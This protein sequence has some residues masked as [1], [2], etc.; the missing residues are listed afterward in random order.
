MT[1]PGEIAHPAI[2]ERLTLNSPLAGQSLDTRKYPFL[3][4]RINRDETPDLFDNDIQAGIKDFWTRFQ[5]PRAQ[6]AETFHLDEEVVRGAV[7]ELLGFNGWAAAACS[8]LTRPFGAQKKDDDWSDL[9]RPG[10][11]Y[12]F[13]LVVH[14]ADHFLIDQLAVIVQLSK[15]LGPNSVFVSLVDYA[16]NDSTPF[17]C[18][19]AEAVMILLGI[20]FRIRQIPPMTSDPTASYYP[21]EEAYTR[22]LA[23]EPLFELDKRRNLRFSRVIWL[24][25][26]TCPND[27]LETIRVSIKN[28]ASMVCSM[29]WKEH[30]GFF[31]YNDRWRTR[32]MDGNLFR[33][34]KSTSPI[35]EA[36]PRD[37]YGGARY[38]LHLPFQVFCCE[39]GA[40]IVDPHK[41][42]YEGI[43]YQSSVA[44]VFNTSAAADGKT[45]KWSE[46]PCMD[47]SQLHFCRDMWMVAF[48][49]GIK[50][51]AH[52]LMVEERAG[53]GRKVHPFMEELIGAMQTSYGPTTSTRIGYANSG[54]YLADETGA[55]PGGGPGMDNEM[56]AAAN[57]PAGG[58]E[59]GPELQEPA[60]SPPEVPIEDAAVYDN[61]AGGVG[62]PIDLA[63]PFDD[64][65]LGPAGGA[66][67]GVVAAAGG[68]VADPAA[69]AL[70]AAQAVAVGA[71]AGALVG[72]GAAVV[73]A[74]VGAAAVGAAA[75]AGV[76]DAAAPA[77][78][79]EVV[80]QPVEDE[81]TVVKPAPAKRGLFT[82]S[83]KVEPVVAAPVVPQ[84]SHLEKRRPRSLPNQDF[85]YAVAKII[86][87]PRCVTTYA[88][89]SHTQLALDL[90]G[91]GEDKEPALDEGGKYVLDEWRTPPESFVCQEMRTTGGTSPFLDRVADS[92]R[93]RS[94]RGEA[95]A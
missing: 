92:D 93:I 53:K 43:T 19:M 42:Y 73:G 86:V 12:Y 77:Q 47:S 62:R 74:A 68:A 14:G 94:D 26:F 52:R 83:K 81:W 82:S 71:G 46:G 32:D 84:R 64:E 88:G 1:P 60:D 90:F 8:S 61:D 91:S 45:P 69:A 36:P 87:N 40:H 55:G 11:L 59:E 95:A 28:E 2:F 50:E 66:V 38:T 34:S 72:G 85:E 17:L 51:E 29:D 6:S 31:I 56:G 15:R 39:S 5:R 54:D 78:E 30:N 9:A 76:V 27:I 49:A 22:N 80:P 44:G 16:S 41:S 63:V 25:G 67:A 48:R 4:T 35:D 24:K 65:Y 20:S 57:A 79:W 7:D 18:D 89:V 3:Q 21:L 75:V 58:P 10:E 23:L 33:G 13:A 37:P 70:V